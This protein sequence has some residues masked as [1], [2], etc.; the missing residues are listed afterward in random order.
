MEAIA[1]IGIIAKFAGVISLAKDLAEVLDKA[2][3]NA[4]TANEKVQLIAVELQL[5]TL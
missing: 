2:I 3:E 4:N 1:I 5:P